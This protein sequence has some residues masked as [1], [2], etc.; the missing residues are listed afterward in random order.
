MLSIQELRGML[1][2]QDADFEILTQ[3][4]PILSAKDAEGIYDPEKS[5]PTFILDSDIG[6]I[7]CVMSVTSGR[8]DLSAMK[9]A[10]GFS[11]L[12]L[13]DGRKIERETGYTVGSVPPVGHG[14]PCIFDQNLLR[15]EYVY[16]GTG[17]ALKTLKIWPRDIVRLNR[18]LGRMQPTADGLL[19]LR[20]GTASDDASIMEL[21]AS[22]FAGEQGI[23]SHMLAIPA[24]QKPRWWCAA[25]DGRV[26][27][28]V[29]GYYDGDDFHMG[30]FAVD[31]TLRGHRI[32]KQLVE[33]AFTNVFESGI[34]RVDMECRDVTVR[35]LL[36][37]GAEIS[38][39]TTLFYGA[40]ATPMVMHRRD[41]RITRDF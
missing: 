30:R 32:G 40:N 34:E 19:V 38:G 11:R 23:P 3:E 35:I 31:P 8:M 13:A 39:E 12:R 21:I 33:F 5:A 25:L 29:A 26:V 2:Q 36:T 27:G 28:T 7:A 17:D 37:M 18:C 1:Q 24:E 15:Y 6:L 41:Y 9:A 10:F 14:L 20:R 4:K 16:A 22:T